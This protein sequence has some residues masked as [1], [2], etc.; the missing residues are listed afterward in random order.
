[1]ISMERRITGQIYRNELRGL[2]F[3]WPQMNADTRRYLPAANDL[4]IATEHLRLSVF[5]CGWLF[6]P[7]MNADN[8]DG[9]FATIFKRRLY[10]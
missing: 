4:T 2:L 5:I 6:L 3:F 7:Q 1:M 8:T 9:S 10:G